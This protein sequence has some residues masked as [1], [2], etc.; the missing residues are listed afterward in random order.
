MLV[1]EPGRA[2]RPGHDDL[3][4]GVRPRSGAPLAMSTLGAAARSTRA[5]AM[6]SIDRPAERR[7]EHAGRHDGPAMARGPLQVRAA[8]RGLV[9]RLVRC[10]RCRV[11]IAEHVHVA[12]AVR[13]HRA[14]V[15]LRLPAV[16]RRR[17]DLLGGPGVPAVGRAGHGQR[18]RQRVALPVAAE[19]RPADVDVAE[20]RAGRPRCRPRSAPCRRTW[21]TTAWRRSPAPIH[22]RVG[23]PAAAAARSSV[24]ETAIASKPLNV[25]VGRVAPKFDVR[26]A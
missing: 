3:V 11:A 6:P 5:P 18:R 12:R 14:A 10:C 26:L 8:V 15:G 7:V 19:R 25:C 4:R 17:A 21:S 9:H 16:V 2:V 24:R 23:P 13:A 22:A 20:V 1:V